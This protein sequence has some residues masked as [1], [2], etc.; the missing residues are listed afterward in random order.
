MFPHGVAD[1]RVRA[2][3]R[4]IRTRRFAA[5]R[6]VGGGQ[7]L[8]HTR[9]RVHDERRVQQIAGD[10]VGA[11]RAERDELIRV[12][13]KG[14]NTMSGFEQPPRDD[15]PELAGR[16]DHEN[17]SLSCAHRWSPQ[18]WSL[19]KSFSL[20]PQN[21]GAASR[22]IARHGVAGRPATRSVAPGKRSLIPLQRWRDTDTVDHDAAGDHTHHQADQRRRVAAC[23][24]V[25]ERIA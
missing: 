6:I 17:R 20:L 1:I 23:H 14:A 7:D 10:D 3:V 8:L 5:H 2:K 13:A 16:P 4:A 21:R 22:R 11:E 18:R 24:P 25:V 12:P 9:T 19:I 15:A